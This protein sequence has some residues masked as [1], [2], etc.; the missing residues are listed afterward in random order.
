[1]NKYAEEMQKV[2]LN[3]LARHLSE[4][5]ATVDTL[6]KLFSKE[7]VPYVSAS[8]ALPRAKISREV[9]T[10]VVRG[11]AVGK[12]DGKAVEVLT[13]ETRRANQRAMEATRPMLRTPAQYADGMWGHAER[14][15]PE[16]VSRAGGDMSKAITGKEYDERLSQV[17]SRF[18]DAS[19]HYEKYKQAVRGAPDRA[20]LKAAAAESLRTARQQVQSVTGVT[21]ISRTPAGTHIMESGARGGV[22]DVG[23]A[24]RHVAGADEEARSVVRHVAPVEGSKSVVLTIPENSKLPRT[25]TLHAGA[26]SSLAN[27][28]VAHHELDEV[29]RMAAHGDTGFYSH[30]GPGILAREY[31][32]QH[33]NPYA[34]LSTGVGNLRQMRSVTGEHK[35]TMRLMGMNPGPEGNLRSPKVPGA[36]VRRADNASPAAI[37][38]ATSDYPI[39]VKDRAAISVKHQESAAYY[40]RLRDVYQGTGS[41]ALKDALRGGGRDAAAKSAVEALQRKPT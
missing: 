25:S 1:M 20:D 5:P 30:Q 13:P 24:L 19:T 33:G 26:L 38:R 4:N 29:R 18:G 36:A 21:A 2:A 32:R 27:S 39:E 7:A 23:K 17:G 41:S 11:S 16:E 22:N 9:P 8:S 14:R 37:E 40:G 6:K 34:H 35:A 3:R 28:Q 10:Q 12:A 15:I 31:Q